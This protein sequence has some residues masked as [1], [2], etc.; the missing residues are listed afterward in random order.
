M[1]AHIFTLITIIAFVLCPMHNYAHGKGGKGGKGGR[2]GKGG[3]GVN[4]G[5][6]VPEL[7]DNTTSAEFIAARIA[8]DTGWP[9][10]E[11]I[12]YG[13]RLAKTL[14]QLSAKEQAEIFYGSD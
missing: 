14:S 10:E 1:K 7:Q 12:T 3:K 2:G 6:P 8:A 9:K 11:M 4:S 13:R 5:R